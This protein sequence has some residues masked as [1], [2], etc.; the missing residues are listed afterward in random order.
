MK[1]LAAT[2]AIKTANVRHGPAVPLATCALLLAVQISPWWY[3]S[4]DSA[5]YLSM[6]R[7]LVRGTGLTNLGS[8]LWW[9]SPGYPALI[10]PAFLMDD[11][12]FFWLSVFQWLLAVGLMLGVYRWSRRVVPDAAVWIASLTVVN[13]GLWLHY[14]RPLSEIA[15]MC[16]LVWAVISLNGLRWQAPKR[17]FAARLS[18]AAV[19]VALL[20]AIRPVGIVLA[21]G[22]A[23]SALLHVLRGTAPWRRAVVASLVVGAAAALP[24]ALFVSHERVMAAE[25][26]GRTYF[27]EFR[28]AARTPLSSWSAGLQMCVSDIGRVCV[29]GLFKSH[30][31]PGDWTDVNMLVHAPFFVMICYGWLRWT[32]E[33][34][35]PFAWYM[36]FYFLLIAAHAMD[37]GARLMLPLLPAL[38]VC[39]WFALQGIGRRRQVIFG[40]CLALQLLVASGY[41]LAFDLPRARKLHMQWAEIDQFVLPIQADPGTVLAWEM[42]DEMYVMLALALDRHVF[43]SGEP[44]AAQAR[45]LVAARD[46]DLPA[47]LVPHQGPTACCLRLF[48]SGAIETVTNG[49]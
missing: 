22:L 12:P 39:A 26:G 37:T 17:V 47:G 8:R 23:V 27:D 45:W 21:P 28:D 18:C 19:L 29:P 5:S 46:H 38:L 25:L 48:S 24:V 34:N 40:V 9:Y 16:V 36:P 44:G 14:R 49:E 20:C 41:W 33:Q 42:S 15:F 13:H 10:S 30:R 2:V 4:I 35:D 1:P 7:S 11:R 43:R 6:A 31:T 3:S 32:R